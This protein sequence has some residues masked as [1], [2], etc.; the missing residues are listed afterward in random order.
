MENQ[1]KI[2]HRSEEER[3]QQGR[4][5]ALVRN[6]LENHGIEPIISG[7]TLLGIVRD[8]DFIA[9]DW[10][11]EF[12]VRYVD[13]KDKGMQIVKSMEDHNFEITMFYTDMENWKI[14]AARSGF[15][16]EIRGWYKD[17]DFYRRRSYKFPISLMDMTCQLEL[18]GEIY[19]APA[20]YDAYLEFVYGDYMTPVKT[21]VK[22]DYLTARFNSTLGLRKKLI[23]FFKKIFLIQSQRG[24]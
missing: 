6:I 15:S 16:F 23:N 11:A 5:L 14:E 1:E 9:W 24:G 21:A 18:R 17:G 8:S 7:G 10:D 12:F 19:R 4:D 13:V 3:A 2:R 20:K 22:R